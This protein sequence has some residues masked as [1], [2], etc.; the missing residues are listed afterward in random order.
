MWVE[1]RPCPNCHSRDNLG[2]WDD[3]SSWCFGCRTYTPPTH[4]IDRIKRI[5]TG[6]NRQVKEGIKLPDDAMGGIPKHAMEWLSKYN[7]TKSEIIKLNLYY[8]PSRELLIFPFFDDQKTI[9]AW[10]GRYFGNKEKYPKYL[11]YGTKNML[12]M[13]PC[14]NPSSNTVSV[15]EDVISAIKVSRVMDAIALLGSHLSLETANRLSKLYSGLVI[16]LDPDKHKAGIEFQARYSPL[17]DS[18]KVVYTERDPK[19]YNTDEI[20]EILK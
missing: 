7:L 15:V 10:Q 12:T 5:V 17:F 3:G 14:A 19:E 1:N 8:S 4:T 2:V 16:W 18:V 13:F 11:T 6:G 9:I 20:K